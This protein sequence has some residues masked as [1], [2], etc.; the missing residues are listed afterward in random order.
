MSGVPERVTFQEHPF[1]FSIASLLNGV[2]GERERERE[3]KQKKLPVRVGQGG[4]GR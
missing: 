2:G 1:Q 4:M 3:N